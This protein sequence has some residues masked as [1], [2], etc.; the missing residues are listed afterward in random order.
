MAMATNKG[1]EATSKSKHKQ[2]NNK[3]QS[4]TKPHKR[5][6]QSHSRQSNTAREIHHGIC[7]VA[8]VTSA[9]AEPLPPPPLPQP[10]P[11]ALPLPPSLPTTNRPLPGHGEARMTVNVEKWTVEC[12]NAA[13]DRYSCR[14]G[15]QH[16][17]Q[18][19]RENAGSGK[20]SSR[21]C[22]VDAQT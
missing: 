14:V 9:T 11:Q 15:S 19:E 5:D 20:L 17:Q 22:A 7:H 21:M 1:V 4:A 3:T 18:G 8:S 6:N 13:R 12:R 10:Q 2:Q 16:T